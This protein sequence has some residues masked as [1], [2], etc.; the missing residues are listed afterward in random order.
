MS[1]YSFVSRFDKF[2][3]SI[4]FIYYREGVLKCWFLGGGW[5]EVLGSLWFMLFLFS[6]SRCVYMYRGLRG[7]GLEVS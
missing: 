2:W 7:R 4:C 3:I 6:N 1:C 5:G